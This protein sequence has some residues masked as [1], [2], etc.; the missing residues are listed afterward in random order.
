[1]KKTLF[2]LFFGIN[3][4]LSSAANEHWFDST[5]I[6]EK[7][8]QGDYGTV[9]SLLVMENGQIVYEGYF[10]GANSDSLHNTRS[11]TKTLTSMAVGA[12]ID[13]GLIQIDTPAATLFTDI[14]PFKNP[15]P[16]KFKVTMKDLLTMS[17][18]LECNDSEQL[19]RGNESRMHLVEDWAS[20]F[21]D[22]PI[23][24][25]PSWSPKPQTAKYGRVFSYC[26]A[27]VEM[28]GM[29]VERVSKM[30]F[31]DYVNHRL[32]KPLGI[33]AFEWQENG[34]GQAHKSG[35][36]SLTT[37]G[38]AKLAELQRQGGVFNGKQ[39][40]SK[41]WTQASIK[42]RVVAFADRKIEYGYLWWLQD[43]QVEENAYQSY[44]M[45]GN[46]GNRVL[47]MPE[48]NLVVVVTKTDF[49]TN[50]MHQAT[51]SLIENAVIDRL[52]RK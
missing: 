20:F 15:D 29:A 47:V 43:Y 13:E 51:Q 9:T 21:W 46:G 3:I 45:S 8:L 5:L 14:V 12:A 44:F 16:R 27:G 23:R 6:K 34:L 39:V 22:L 28:A 19:S 17:S 48:H 38:L 2:T 32:F 36:L 24:G 35:G 33:T 42:P 4:S 50:G 31:Q 52:S 26:S 25:F 49:N 7:I 18:I 11:V 30:R 41:Q 40:L 37:K 10:N 1:M